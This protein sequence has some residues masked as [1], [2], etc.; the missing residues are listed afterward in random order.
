[1]FPYDPYT[2]PN[3]NLKFVSFTYFGPFLHLYLYGFYFEFGFG[4]DVNGIASPEYF[5]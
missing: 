2:Y 5:F 4:H 3:A 1:M